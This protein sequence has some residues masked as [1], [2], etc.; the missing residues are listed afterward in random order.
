MKTIKGL[1]GIK[2]EMMFK[3]GKPIEVRDIGY[4]Y[5]LKDVI[6]LIDLMEAKWGADAGLTELKARIE[7]KDTSLEESEH[8]K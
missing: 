3:K 4:L 5:A 8:D 2:N 6:K 7:G 1:E